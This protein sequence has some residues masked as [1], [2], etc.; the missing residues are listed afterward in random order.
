MKWRKVWPKGRKGQF[1]ILG[2]GKQL[3]DKLVKKIPKNKNFLIR[4]IDTAKLPMREQISII[5]NTD[6]LVGI[7]GAGLSLSI[8]L[9]K[10][11]ILHEVLHSDNLK[12]LSMMSKMS[13]H[14]TYSDIINAEV[15][16]IRGN[17][18]IFFDESEFCKKVLEHMKENNYL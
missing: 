2:N 7:H 14:V 4:L 12:V 8:F 18:Y 11:S 17:E 10:N 6:Y 5:K 3:T 16:N 9:P 1:R 15:K 13:G